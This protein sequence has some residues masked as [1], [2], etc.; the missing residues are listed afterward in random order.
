M[1]KTGAWYLQM[2]EDAS[3]LTKDEFIKKHGEHNLDLWNEVHEEL[4]DLEEM[5]S[6]LKDMQSRFNK[7]VSRMNKS[8][9]GKI[10]K[11]D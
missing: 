3:D 4:G 7:V 8:L 1:S 10:L 5:Q 2:C 9:A 11:N 6:K